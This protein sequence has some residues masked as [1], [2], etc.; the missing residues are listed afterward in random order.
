MIKLTVIE[1]IKVT[2]ASDLGN[3]QMSHLYHCSHTWRH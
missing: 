1:V 2:V 3:E